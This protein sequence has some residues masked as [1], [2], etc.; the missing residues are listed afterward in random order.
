MFLIIH[1]Y[2]FFRNKN[3]FNL[4]MVMHG[5]GMVSSCCRVYP[6][7]HRRGRGVRGHHP[8]VGVLVVVSRGSKHSSNSKCVH[9]VTQ[10][11][12]GFWH[13]I[14]SFPLVLF[15]FW[16]CWLICTW[17]ESVEVMSEVRL[18]VVVTIPT[19]RLSK[20]G[21]EGEGAAERNPP[22][23][24]D[25]HIKFFSHTNFLS[26]V[27]VWTL[28]L[29]YVLNVLLRSRDGRRSPARFL[30]AL[31]PPTP[32]ERW[33]LLWLGER[34][35]GRIGPNFTWLETSKWN[36]GADFYFPLSFI[37]YC[38]GFF[39]LLPPRSIT[40]TIQKSTQGHIQT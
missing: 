3:L 33:R 25:L 9:G 34:R 29:L 27:S 4:M 21:N 26:F 23:L 11:A 37:S 10:S 18:L 19:V 1:F 16:F 31:L 24:T 39:S 14:S 2:L 20:G 22:R 30:L 36:F 32:P 6:H 40:E 8:A 5:V 12:S 28:S 17:I 15:L 13:L 7:S 35:V 38:V